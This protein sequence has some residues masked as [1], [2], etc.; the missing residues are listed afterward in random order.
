M[1]ITQNCIVNGMPENVYHNDPTPA[2]AG[3]KDSASLSSST[4]KDCVEL[5]MREARASIRRLNPEKKEEA[6]SDAMN[7][8][9]LAHDFILC[10]GESKF[11]V[12]PFD[13]WRSNDAK[14]VKADIIRRGLIPLNQSTQG[15]L[16]DVRLMKTRLFE[17]LAENRDGFHNIL[18]KG[19]PEQSAFAFDGTIWNRARLDWQDESHENLIVDYKTTGVEFGRWERNDLWDEKFYQ[20]VHYKRVLDLIRNPESA[21]ATFCFVLQQ[22]YGEHLAKIIIIDD[23]YGEMQKTRYDIGYHRFV[24]ATRSGQWPGLPPYVSYACPPT[25]KLTQWEEQELIAKESEERAKAES[26]PK[27]EDDGLKYAL[28]GG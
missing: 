22:S 16:E 9:D 11:E 26:Q 1:L 27:K 28:A 7:L 6:G 21:P 24:A 3:F 19:K 18:L 5:T 23:S 4:A 17:Q 25:W 13:A 15:V 12:A 20:A 2:L 14:A 8:G 10:G